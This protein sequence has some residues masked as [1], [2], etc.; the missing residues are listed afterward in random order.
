MPADELPPEEIERRM[1]G[2]LRVALATPP[3][4]PIKGARVRT[5]PAER[6]AAD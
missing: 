5:R 4:Q 2:G 3:K 1:E 6:R